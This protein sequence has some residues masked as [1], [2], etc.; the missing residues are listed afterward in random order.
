MSSLTVSY[1]EDVPR[2]PEDAVPQWSGRNKTPAH[3]V[4]VTGAHD[5]R[6][7][8]HAF[9][10]RATSGGSSRH[11]TRACVALARL[12]VLIRPHRSA[13][14]PRRDEGGKTRPPDGRRRSGG[15]RVGGQRRVAHSRAVGL[16]D[17]SLCWLRA[18]PFGSRFT[19]P[20]NVRRD[21]AVW[22]WLTSRGGDSGSW[23]PSRRSGD[24]NPT[25]KANASGARSA[26]S[27]THMRS[28]R[29]NHQS[30]TSDPSRHC[31]CG[32]QIDGRGHLC[33]KC[34]ERLRWLRRTKGRR[35]DD[36]RESNRA[37]HSLFEAV[38]TA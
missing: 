12:H 1:N 2:R 10:G 28:T 22:C 32:A 30:T 36:W 3:A 15:V 13:V 37:T 35:R 31:P 29:K 8:T 6:G 34:R 7:T 11:S 26:R 24:S 27:Q 5:P 33:R 18:Q 20:S 4:P 25:P 23:K 21:V 14:R 19:T 16:P 38:T 17:S 9:I